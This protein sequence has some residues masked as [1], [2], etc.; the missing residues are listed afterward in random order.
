MAQDEIRVDDVGT[1]L[2]CLIKDGPVIVDLTGYTTAEIRLK[3]PDGTVVT[4]TGI[5]PVPETDG[6]VTYTTVAGDL[7]Q[8]GPWRI[9][10]HVALPGGDWRSDIDC[11]TVHANL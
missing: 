1:V 5:V 8:E 6:L 7:D 11:F 10:A 4:K 2:E 3:K 9:Q